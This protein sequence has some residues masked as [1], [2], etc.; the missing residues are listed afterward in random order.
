MAQVITA[1]L[2]EMVFEGREK[3]YGA[4]SLRKNYPH[5]LLTGTVIIGM[6]AFLFTFGPLIAK[7]MGFYQAEVKEN[8]KTIVILNPETLPPPPS[9]DEEKPPLPPPPRIEQE[10]RTIAFQIPEPT[11]DDEMDDESASIVLIDSLKEVPNIGL[12]DRD[13]ADEVAFFPGEVDGTGTIPEVIVEKELSSDIFIIADEEPTP[14]NMADVQKL[15]GYPQIARDAGIQGSVIVR[16]LVDKKGNYTKHK[17]INQVH[18]ILEKAVTDHIDKLRFT[19]A[20]QGKKPIQ[21]W[22][23]IPFNFRLL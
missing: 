6:A 4:F 17:V 7:S 21:F 10:V 5:H 1:S 23:N 15:I 18:P 3:G 22:V 19:P 8:E 16:V 14:V 11:P 12:V 9:I 13:G 20:I 2:D